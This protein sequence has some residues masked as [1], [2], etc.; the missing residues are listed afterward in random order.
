MRT[1]RVTRT[2]TASRTTVASGRRASRTR[3]SR[4]PAPAPAR[5]PRRTRTGGGP[6][7]GGRGMP[8]PPPALDRVPPRGRA[9]PQPVEL[10]E[11]EPHPVRPL[12]PAADLGERPLVDALLRL[13]EAV[14]VV[15]VSRPG[16]DDVGHGSLD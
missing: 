14:Q 9:G 4:T 12:P 5:P 2:R 3:R 16:F 1:R 8:R 6:G 15:R 13:H 7:P 11:D 10:R